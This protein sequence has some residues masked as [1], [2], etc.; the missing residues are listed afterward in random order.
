MR[1][2]AFII[3]ILSI[4][5]SFT[6]GVSADTVPK[7]IE[8]ILSETTAVA[9]IGDTIIL[10]ATTTKHGSSYSDNW[11]N[12]AKSITEFDPITETY[13][14]KAFFTAEKPGIYNIS[15]TINMT[16]G[17]SNTVFSKTVEKTIEV[18]DSVTL[19]GADIRDLEVTPI[20]NADGSISVYSAFG[21]IYALWSDNTATPNGSLFFFFNPDET[22]KNID[23]TLNINGIPT[24]YTVTANR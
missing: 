21:T 23:V 11:D 4:F 1:K 8:V 5:F 10:T 2:L 15:Y 12:A 18:I 22:T 19:I 6:I 16:A 7:D 17:D 20:Y 13:I 14:S 9:N 3:A 24:I